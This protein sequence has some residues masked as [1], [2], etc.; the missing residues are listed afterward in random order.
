MVD[1]PDLD[2]AVE[3]ARATLEQ[4]EVLAANARTL[5]GRTDSLLA[6]RAIS[7]EESDQRSADAAA[8][9]AAVRVAGAELARLEEQQKFATVRAPF[10]AV[11]AA[12]NIDRGDR[13]RGDAATAEG[14]LFHLVRLD[15]LRFAVSATPDLALRLGAGTPATVRFNE[16]PGREFPATVARSSRIFDPATGTMRVELHLGNQDLT[17]PAGLTGTT[18]FEL[19]PPPGTYLVPTNTLVL[20]AGQTTLATV[21]DGR[22]AFVDVLPGRTLGPNV[23]VTS[24]ALSPD[25]RVIINPNA[26]LRAGDPVTLATRED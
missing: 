6:A 11:V 13:V 7:Q 8:A 17:L 24:A 1:A 19:A 14:W 26:L 16:F 22:L 18:T 25:T 2:R 12:R 23:E 10:D 21:Q 15:R 20:R 3:A 5:A 9:E 4:A